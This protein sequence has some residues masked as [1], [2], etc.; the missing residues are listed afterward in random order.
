MKIEREDQ[1][2]DEERSKRFEEHKDYDN[3]P[4]KDFDKPIKSKELK[5]NNQR[6]KAG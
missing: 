1:R 6:K 3:F 4:I 2:R 5:E